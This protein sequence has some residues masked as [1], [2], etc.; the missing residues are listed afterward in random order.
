MPLAAAK[1]GV[2][3]SQLLQALVAGNAV[4]R[5]PA[6]PGTKRLPQP[7]KNI[8]SGLPLYSVGM[9]TR[10]PVGVMTLKYTTA[11]LFSVSP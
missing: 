9:R 10:F 2:G 7:I 6:R 8:F 11:R 4:R 1:I 5:F 3:K